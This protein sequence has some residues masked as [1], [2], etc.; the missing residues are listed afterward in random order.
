MK[1]IISPQFKSP[2]HPPL[3]FSF[4]RMTSLIFSPT[5]ASKNE[6]TFDFASPHQLINCHI[7]WSQLQQSFLHAFSSCHFFFLLPPKLTTVYHLDIG[8]TLPPGLPTLHR[9]PIYS[10]KLFLLRSNCGYATL[11]FITLQG[12]GPYHLGSG[13]EKMCLS[14]KL[15]SYSISEIRSHPL[16]VSALLF[17]RTHLCSLKVAK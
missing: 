16:N 7:Q 3:T 10:A 5:T 6:V 2:I 1:L 11:L 15:T 9:Y 12:N 13:S 14:F 17:I 4:L 8:N